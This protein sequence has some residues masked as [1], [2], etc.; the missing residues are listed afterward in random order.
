MTTLAQEF[1]FTADQA[2]AITSKAFDLLESGEF[3]GAAVIFEGL[4][5][6][7]PLDAGVHAALGTVRHEQGKLGDAEAAYSEALRLDAKTPLALVNRGELRCKRGDLG[8]LDDL[9][10]AA[11]LSS[12]IQS[13]AQALISLYTR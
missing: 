3:D 12:P 10:V 1:G 9:K 13:R 7:N 5:V 8:G 4:L 2:E 6:L 11:G